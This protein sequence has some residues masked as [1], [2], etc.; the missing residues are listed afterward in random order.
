MGF[1]NTVLG[2]KT[3]VFVTREQGS[4]L[5]NLANYQFDKAAYLGFEAQ[6]F[7]ELGVNARVE[8]KTFDKHDGR[9]D[10]GNLTPAPTPAG[11]ILAANEVSNSRA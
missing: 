3:H 11:A 2:P 1:D 9:M 7:R 8:G 5:L 6:L 10:T 4:A